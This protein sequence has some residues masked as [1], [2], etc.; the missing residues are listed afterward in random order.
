MALTVSNVTL[1]RDQ[2]FSRSLLTPI[3]FLVM[4]CMEKNTIHVTHLGKWMKL[5]LDD[6]N[7]TGALDFQVPSISPTML[8]LT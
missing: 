6:G 3:P 2:A 5:L 8:T 1:P 4:A 7:W